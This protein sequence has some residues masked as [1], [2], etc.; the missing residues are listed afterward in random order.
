MFVGVGKFSTAAVFV[1]LGRIVEPSITYPRYSIFVCKKKHFNSALSTRG[2]ER[3]LVLR[4]V[5]RYILPGYL[6]GLEY[7]QDTPVRVPY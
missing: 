6:R 7:R 1:G 5:F 4:G 3:S 2:L